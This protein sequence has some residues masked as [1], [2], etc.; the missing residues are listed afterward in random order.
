MNSICF[1]CRKTKILT[2]EHVIPQALG[3][4][5]KAK[6]YCKECNENFGKNIDTEITNQ[7]GNIVTILKIKR[8]RGKLQPFEV[9][10][11]DK[12]V[13]LVFNGEAFR[14]KDPIVKIES[15]A[16]GKKLKSANITAKFL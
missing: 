1:A 7:F 3:G 15:E 14:R 11:I 8:D 16:D 4:R 6:L 10:D 2:D 9:E 5:L 13:T 12:K